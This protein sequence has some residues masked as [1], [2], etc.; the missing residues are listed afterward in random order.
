M[1]LERRH[2]AMAAVTAAASTRIWGANDRISIALLGTG[3]RGR[4]VT[5][6]AQQQPNVV[7]TAINDVNPAQLDSA[8]SKEFPKAETSGDFRAVLDRKDIDAVVIGSPDHWHVPMLVAA[9]DAGKDVYV[10]KPLT[11]T[12]AEGKAAIDAVHRTKRIVQVGY[13]QRSTPHYF[14]VKQLVQDGRLGKIAVAETWWYQDYVGSDWTRKMLSTDN[15]DW[16]NWLGTAPMRDVEALRVSRWRWFWDYG[17]GHLTDLFSH[18][19][20]AVHWITGDDQVV[21]SNASGSKAYYKQFECPD[22]IELSSVYSGGHMVTYHG[23]IAIGTDSGGIIL[24][25]VNANVELTRGGFKMFD[26]RIKDKNEPVMTARATRDGTIDHVQNWLECMKT[27]RQPNS[28]VAS[29]VT[30]ANAAHYGNQSYRTGQRVKV[31][32]DAKKAG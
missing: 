6:I 24:R 21:E 15:L 3:G 1:K 27:R 17:G 9:C 29:A 14:T 25:G 22:T 16:K 11:K 20:D 5:N 31:A 4:H 26:P 13:Q 7:V 2:F 19:V 18:W 32:A 10:E 8:K 30:S 28:D 23:S 12:I